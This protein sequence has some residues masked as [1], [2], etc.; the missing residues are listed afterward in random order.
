MERYRLGLALGF[1]FQ[2]SLSLFIKTKKNIFF[3]L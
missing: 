1:Y 2:F 3:H